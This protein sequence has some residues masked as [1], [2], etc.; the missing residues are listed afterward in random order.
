[1][2]S[3]PDALYAGSLSSVGCVPDWLAVRRPPATPASLRT[4]RPPCCPPSPPPLTRKS[5]R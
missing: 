4:P 5:C 1:V 2:V 3:L